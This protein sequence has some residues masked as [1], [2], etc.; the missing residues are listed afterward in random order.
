M[1]NVNRRPPAGSTVTTVRRIT[2]AALAQAISAMFTM[3]RMAAEEQQ[4]RNPS[5][6]SWPTGY[7]RNRLSQAARRRRA[8]QSH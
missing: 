1:E 8:R 4:H 7:P 6:Y 2:G 5:A 3:G